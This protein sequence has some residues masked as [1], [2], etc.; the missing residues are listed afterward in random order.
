MPG[1]DPAE[2]IRIVVDEL[3]DF[4]FLPELPSPGPGADLVGRTAALLV[5]MPVE[6]ATGGW[7]IAERPG[8]VMRT[9]RSMLSND[10]DTM[11]EQLAGYEGPLKI[12]LAG[13]VDAGG[14]HRAAQDP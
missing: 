5:D 7:R 13:P 3:P 2:A 6:T 10:L 14:Q 8:R 11:E 1:T 4:P 9:A 12:S